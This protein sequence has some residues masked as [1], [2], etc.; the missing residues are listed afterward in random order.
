MQ[1]LIRAT[2]LI[3]SYADREGTAP[4][5]SNVSMHWRI[6]E[7]IHERLKR[8]KN[9]LAR[10]TNEVAVHNLRDSGRKSAVEM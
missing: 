4:A 8:I 10:I 5:K 7:I 3:T 6:E 2:N 1:Y 9:L